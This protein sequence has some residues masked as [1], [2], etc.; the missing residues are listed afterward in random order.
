MF[1]A[2]NCMESIAED[3]LYSAVVI[4]GGRTT[5]E[6]LN[7]PQATEFVERHYKR[8]KLIAATCTGL[9]AISALH[10]LKNHKV[11]VHSRLKDRVEAR[12]YSDQALT[13]DENVLTSRGIVTILDFALK[14]VEI[15]AGTEAK[16]S[17]EYEILTD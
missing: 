13:L 12:E 16:E 15:L 5:T 10:I 7:C 4:V 6:A 9:V 14:I 11:T 17:V 3:D 1:R 2:E 8:K